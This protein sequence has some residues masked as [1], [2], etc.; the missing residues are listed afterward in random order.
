[1]PCFVCQTNVNNLRT[2]TTNLHHPSPIFNHRSPSS[3]STTTTTLV[4]QFASNCPFLSSTSVAFTAVNWLDI[5]RAFRKWRPSKAE[6]ETKGGELLGILAY[7]YFYENS[8]HTYL[9]D[10]RWSQ[11][12][13]TSN[14]LPHT[15]AGRRFGYPI[16][17]L[18]THTL[19]T[20]HCLDTQHSHSKDSGP[21][22]KP[23]RGIVPW[24]TKTPTKHYCSGS[25]LIIC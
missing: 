7:F 22:K 24:R 14:H 1:M 17:L 5:S 19:S 2:F 4:L 9:S 8:Q 23:A 6:Y 25:H 12:I 11:H 15:T 16:C 18:N 21:Y 3:V 13:S 10:L 20:S